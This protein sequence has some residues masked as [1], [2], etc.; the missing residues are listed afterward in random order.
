MPG[1][2]GTAMEIALF[3]GAARFFAAAR[4]RDGA[5]AGSQGC[6]DRVETVHD[7]ILAA[8]HHAIAALESPDAA[9]GANIDIV[10]L[11]RRQFLG[12]ADVVDIVGIAAVDDDVTGIKQRHKAGDRLIDHGGR[13]HQP[14]CAGLIE[15][16]HKI[17]ER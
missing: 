1:A 14:D 4:S 5:D 16:L 10:D 3:G 9:A 17:G 7:V 11:L 15:L 2:I 8:D 12:A 6:K 13:H